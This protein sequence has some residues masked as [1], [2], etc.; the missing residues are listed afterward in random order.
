MAS[1]TCILCGAKPPLTA[2]HIWPDWYNRQQ[3][4]NFRYEAESIVQGNVRRHGA[5]SLNLAARVLC[6]E[7]KCNEKWGSQLEA[8]VGPILTP[9][10]RGHTRRLTTGETQL[11]SAWFFLKAMASEYL[12][13][14]D[15]RFF[16]LEDGKHL[17]ATLRPPERT[18]I[19]MGRYV[20]S[21]AD[22]GWL[23][24]RGAARQVSDDPP[25]AVLWHSVTYSIG[26]V[27][28]HLF[29]VS[30]PVPLVSLGDLEEPP[31]ISFRFDWAPGDWASGLLRIWPTPSIPITWPPEKAFDDDGFIYLAERWQQQDASANPPP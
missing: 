14:R 11:T 24:D 4:T 8:R 10:I 6:R 19:W 15:T 1:K 3:P 25:A 7:Q 21:R 31:T 5:R 2:E 13:S 17:R 30:S 26:Q 12:T 28:L 20:G 27:L 9:M 23:M 16:R 18:Q 29:G 22:A